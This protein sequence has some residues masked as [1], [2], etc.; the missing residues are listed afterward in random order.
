[1][2]SDL[3]IFFKIPIVANLYQGLT[4]KALITTRCSGHFSAIDHQKQ[5]YPNGSCLANVTTS[6]TIKLVIVQYEEVS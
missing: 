1:M 4:T 2:L 6:R 3:H 5:L